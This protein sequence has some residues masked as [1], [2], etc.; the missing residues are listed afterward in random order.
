MPGPF[1]S[2]LAYFTG[3]GQPQTAAPAPAAGATPP[4]TAPSSPGGITGVLDNPLTQG[5]LGAYLGYLATPRLYGGH[6]RA[7]GIAG[8]QGLQGYEQARQQ[9]LAI[10]LQQAQ[11]QEAQ[12]QATLGQR[13]L[14]PLPREAV[15]GLQQWRA[16]LA[17]QG[18]QADPSEVAYASSLESMARGGL[19]SSDDLLKAMSSFDEQK[20]MYE[21]AHAREAAA[22]AAVYPYA[23]QILQQQARGGGGPS[24]GLN[25]PGGM[26]V[27]PSAPPSGPSSTSPA[28]TS[29]AAAGGAP[30][31]IPFNATSVSTGD[32]P[33]VGKVTAYYNPDDGG[34]YY[35]GASG[36]QP[37]PKS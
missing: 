29:T 35:K 37:I 32:I 1:D 3:Q 26:T 27:S 12:T 34:W 25:L 22:T 2:L 8:L 28:P 23:T 18:P 9:E 33:G 17:A 16:K 13:A 21:L 5:A 4:A 36:W 10:P 15:Q 11:L 14:Q 20:R 7:L 6:G 19:I 31:D 24:V 30:A